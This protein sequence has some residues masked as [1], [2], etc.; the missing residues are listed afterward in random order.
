MTGS[1]KVQRWNDKD[2]IKYFAKRQ[3]NIRKYKRLARTGELHFLPSGFSVN[4]TW[5]G[6]FKGWIAFLINKQYENDEERK[7]YAG[8][9]Q[10]LQTELGIDVSEF[11]ELKG[12]AIEF[13][14]KPE[15]KD[16]ADWA[17]DQELSGDEILNILIKGDNEFAKKLKK[18]R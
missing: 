12:L 4:Q 11:D 1:G 9:I 18:Q 13:I 2:S 16:L 17:Q 14:S 10:K 8:V 7:Y 15:N 6:L 3:A 5:G